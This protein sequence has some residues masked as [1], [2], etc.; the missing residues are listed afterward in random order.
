MTGRQVDR[1]PCGRLSRGR[2]SPPRSHR[3]TIRRRRGARAT[4]RTQAVARARE[5]ELL[6]WVGQ[7]C[8]FDSTFVHARAGAWLSKIHLRCAPLG[9]GAAPS[10]PY[11]AFSVAMGARQR[12]RQP[13]AHCRR[14]ADVEPAWQRERRDP[15]TARTLTAST[16]KHEGD[17]VG[18][19]VR[20]VGAGVGGHVVLQ[21]RTLL[22]TGG[23]Q[24]RR[25]GRWQGRH[26]PRRTGLCA[27]PSRELVA[28]SR[29]QRLM[30]SAALLVAIQVV[31]AVLPGPAEGGGSVVGPVG[32]VGL[33][34]AVVAAWVGAWQRRLWARPLLWWCAVAG[35]ARQTG[36]RA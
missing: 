28:V 25:A 15:R 13:G 2:P 23:R 29:Q 7:A 1:A 30:A 3:P 36:D 18:Q 20:G 19:H 16:K 6:Q 24:D 8:S 32:G 14:R 26:G 9:D 27:M 22:G 35:A 17:P 10:R 12:D 33:L 31:H 21:A 34:V 4:A 5:R 11:R